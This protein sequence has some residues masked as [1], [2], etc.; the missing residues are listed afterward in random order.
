M[1]DEEGIK[2]YTDKEECNHM[3]KSRKDISRNTGEG[4]ANIDVDQSN[5]M[6]TSIFSSKK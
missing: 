1:A 2:Y 3:E 6:N 5:H 4:E